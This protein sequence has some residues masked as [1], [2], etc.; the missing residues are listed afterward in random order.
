M[1]CRQIGPKKVAN[2]ALGPDCQGPN[3]PPLIKWQIGSR[4]VWPWGPTVWGLIV[5]GPTVPCVQGVMV[6]ACLIV[7]ACVIILANA[8]MLACVKVLACVMV[9]A[10]VISPTRGSHSR[11]ARRAR[12]TMSRGPKGRQLEV[13][14]RRP[15]YTSSLKYHIRWPVVLRPL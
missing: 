12:R 6:L 8:M 10:R 9:F 13:R 4:T 5:W 15:P 7:L 11:S 2:L 14:A 3:C 1:G